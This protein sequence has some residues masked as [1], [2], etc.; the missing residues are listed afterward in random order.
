MALNGNNDRY[1]F[2]DKSIT[3]FFNQ[4]PGQDISD[5]VNA[6]L[7]SMTPEKAAQNKACLQNAFYRGITDFRKSPKCV[8]PNLIPLA[9]SGIIVFIILAKCKCF[10]DDF[11]WTPSNVSRLE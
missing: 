9:F 5:N 4:Q 2:I 1:A 11:R 10:S 6:V 3:D 8:G 7:A